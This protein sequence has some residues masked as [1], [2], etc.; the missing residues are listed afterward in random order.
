MGKVK[1]TL[2]RSFEAKRRE[3]PAAVLVDHQTTKIW[4]QKKNRNKKLLTFQLPLPRRE[5][6]RSRQ[7]SHE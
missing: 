2:K 6:F 4:K 1:L 7:I 3:R 5:K